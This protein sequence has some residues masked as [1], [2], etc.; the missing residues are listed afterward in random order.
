MNIISDLKD[1]AMYEKC[2]IHPNY[3]CDKIYL[4]QNAKERRICDKCLKEN[5]YLLEEI[6][7]IRDLIDSDENTILDSYPPL[8]DHSLLPQL[9]L[10]KVEL[11]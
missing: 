9:I 10:Q 3:L 4:N 2:K 5:K 7:C 11:V 8:K 6:L 1:Y